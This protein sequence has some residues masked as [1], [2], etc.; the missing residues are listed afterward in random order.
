MEL[1]ERGA[2]HLLQQ[3][4]YV[5][6]FALVMRQDGEIQFIDLQQGFARQEDA[7]EATMMRLIPMAQEKQ[8]KA[9]GIVVQPWDSG[10]EK[11]PSLGFDIEQVGHQ[12]ILVSLTYNRNENNVTFGPKAYAVVPPM[13]L[14]E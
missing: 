5:P 6:V 3:G 9:S 4:D 10:G 12:R 13:L 7:L 1:L 8:I 2:H 11:L 14:A